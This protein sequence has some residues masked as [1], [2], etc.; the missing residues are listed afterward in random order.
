MF[1]IF[2]KVLNEPQSDKATKEKNIHP[3]ILIFGLNPHLPGYR[4]G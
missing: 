2:Q 4:S 3:N 1:P